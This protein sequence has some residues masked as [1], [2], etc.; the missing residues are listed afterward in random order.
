MAPIQWSVPREVV[1]PPKRKPTTVETAIIEGHPD[2]FTLYQSSPTMRSMW[3]LHDAAGATHFLFAIGWE[4]ARSVAG[5]RIVEILRK[6]QRTKK[7]RRA[8]RR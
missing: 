6:G 8:S 1:H 5:A 2:R 4:Q 3:S 7:P